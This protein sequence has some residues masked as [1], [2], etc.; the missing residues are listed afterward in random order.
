MIIFRIFQMNKPQ[1][2]RRKNNNK[3]LIALIVDG[4]L[5]LKTK[6]NF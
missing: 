5:A 1:R 6:L 2:W 4:S 3:N